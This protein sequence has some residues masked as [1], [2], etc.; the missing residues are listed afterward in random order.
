MKRYLVLGIGVV[1]F[2]AAGIAVAQVSAGDVI[3]VCA[4]EKDG[5]LRLVESD[6]DCLKKDSSCV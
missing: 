1:L 5:A 2:I 4:S 6:A 3:Y